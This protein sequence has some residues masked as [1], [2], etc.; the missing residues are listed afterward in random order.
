MRLGILPFLLSNRQT[1]IQSYQWFPFPEI[2]ELS[3]TSWIQYN[4]PLPWPMSEFV[5]RAGQKGKISE[6]NQECA[7][8]AGLGLVKQKDLQCH[9]APSG[10]F[11]PDLAD[12]ERGTEEMI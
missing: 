11:S 2:S 5:A 10:S 4:L 7:S 1:P 8:Y 3:G 9:S 6:Q 12:T